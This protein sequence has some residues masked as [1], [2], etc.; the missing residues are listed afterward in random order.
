MTLIPPMSA[1]FAAPHLPA[2][3]IGAFP[4]KRFAG[5][6]LGYSRLPA[7]GRQGTVAAVY[8][9]VRALPARLRQFK[10]LSQPQ[11]C[12]SLRVQAGKQ[13]RSSFRFRLY[14]LS[15]VAVH[16]QQHSEENGPWVTRSM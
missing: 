7:L 10:R 6:L 4:F 1:V 8:E 3:D 14:G 9:Y 12:L 11:V 2:C 15:C 5:S 13:A 16:R